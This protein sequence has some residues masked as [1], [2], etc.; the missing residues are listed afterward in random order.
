MA[1]D[2]TVVVSI[3]GA[4]GS[5][6]TTFIKNLISC[7]SKNNVLNIDK[8]VFPIWKKLYSDGMS[9]D[10]KALFYYALMKKKNDLFS[11][12]QNDKKLYI[13]ERY[14]HTTLAFNKAAAKQEPIEVNKPRLNQEDMDLFMEKAA[15]DLEELAD[16]GD[17]FDSYINREFPN[18]L[19]YDILGY[20]YYSESN[21]L[22][23]PDHYVFMYA[24]NETLFDRINKRKTT[25]PHEK[26]EFL[27]V[28][29]D[30]LRELYNKDSERAVFIDT[31][32]IGKQDALKHALRQRDLYSKA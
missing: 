16:S 15:S 27:F 8:E 31:D 32:K 1:K 3:D 2:M 22:S 7:F 13:L 30:C 12:H 18:I 9:R 5:G 14:G 29:N 11:V 21:V 20:D 28:Y 4:D 23:K 25:D 24:S 26:K 17:C 10:V 19:S 6:K